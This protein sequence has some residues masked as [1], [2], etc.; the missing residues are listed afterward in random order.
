MH[1]HTIGLYQRSFWIIAHNTLYHI[2]FRKAAESRVHTHSVLPL[3]S[4]SFKSQHREMV[5]CESFGHHESYYWHRAFRSSWPNLPLTSN[6][7]TASPK[8]SP[9]CCHTLS[10]FSFFHIS[11]YTLFYFL[12]FVGCIKSFWKRGGKKV[13]QNKLH[14]NDWN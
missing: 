10:C 1:R 5:P 14:K 3:P 4:V 13:T 8:K 2:Y 11:S 9:I 7:G 6:E 12:I